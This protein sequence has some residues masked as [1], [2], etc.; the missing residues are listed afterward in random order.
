[1]CQ[2]INFPARIK[3]QE[4]DRAFDLCQSLRRTVQRNP[5]ETLAGDLPIID[6]TRPVYSEDDLENNI[7][8]E[9]LKAI[10]YLGEVRKAIGRQYMTNRQIDAL[11]ADLQKEI[12]IWL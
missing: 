2:I 4:D 1:M 9:R 10:A 8:F 11:I 5:L 6:R 3:T 12:G 7:K